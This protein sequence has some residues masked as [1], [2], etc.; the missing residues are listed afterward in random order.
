MP[1]DLLE[2][3]TP[4]SNNA[5]AANTTSQPAATTT[6]SDGQNT[7]NAPWWEGVADEYKTVA[8][9]FKTPEEALKSYSNLEK[10]LGADK[11]DIIRLP[12]DRTPEAMAEFYKSIGRPENATDYKYTSLEG[13]EIDEKGLAEWNGQFHE[14]GLT[15]EQA[16]KVVGAYDKFITKAKEQ[17][18]IEHQQKL[19]SGLQ[20]LKSEW[21]IAYDAQ[22]NLVKNMIDKLARTPEEAK[23]IRAEIGTSPNA[24][25]LLARAAEQLSGP[26][27][28]SPT[29]GTGGNGQLT[30]G[31]AKV[32]MQEIRAN[33]LFMDKTQM[34]NPIRVALVK[35]Y[36]ELSKVADG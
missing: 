13:K 27:E 34:Q 16:D 14:M 32:K 35:Q 5:P 7:N 8:S 36:S 29:R 15:N 17:A 11:N 9:K 2:N 30:P 3:P 33:P 26:L 19:A 22:T 10:H 28:L 1:A 12:K 4:A 20:D 21:G 23:A 25:K 6:Q 24:L 31:Q 18:E